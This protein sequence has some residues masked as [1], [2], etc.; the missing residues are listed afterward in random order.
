MEHEVP[1]SRKIATVWIGAI[2]FVAFL[3]AILLSACTEAE[4]ARTFNYGKPGRVTCHAAGGAYFD[5]FSTGRIEKHGESDGFYFVSASTGRLTEVTG[6]CV[7][8]YGVTAGPGFKT[9]R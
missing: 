3:I 1:R 8:D 7:V 5:D 2:I 4:S 6:D 9:I